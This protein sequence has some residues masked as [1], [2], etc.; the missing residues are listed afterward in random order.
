MLEYIFIIVL[1]YILILK[2]YFYYYE[3]FLFFWNMFYLIIVLGYNFVNSL[4]DYTS[5]EINVVE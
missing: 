1:E 2:Q 5:F 3:I 4:S